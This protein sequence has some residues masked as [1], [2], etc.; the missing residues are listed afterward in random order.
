MEYASRNFLG[1]LFICSL[2]VRGLIFYGYL[3]RDHHYWQVDSGTYQKVAES[4]A[5]GKGIT[6]PDGTAHFYRVP[7]YSLFLA[8]CYRYLGVD[9]KNVLWIQLI[10]ASL[11]PLLIFFLA[12]L[13]FPQQRL[14]AYCASWWS[15]FHL[16]LVL[17]AGFFMTESLFILFL[18][19]FFL[20]FFSIVRFLSCA[21]S[22]PEETICYDPGLTI[23]SCYLPEPL[24]E[25]MGLIEYYYADS[26]I[27]KNGSGP[28]INPFEEEASIN[29]FIAGIF[30]GAATLFRPVGHYLLGLSLILIVCCKLDLWAKIRRSTMLFM[31]WVLIAGWWLIRNYLLLGTLFFHTLPGGHFLYLSAARVAMVINNCSYT[32]A[33]EIVHQEADLR[34]ELARQEK[35]SALN[36]IEAC[37]VNEALAREYF[38]AQPLVTARLWF[39]DIFRSLFS[40]YSAEIIYLEQGRASVNYFDKEHGF[41]QMFMRYFCPNINA[42]WLILLVYAEIFFFLMLWMGVL[43]TAYAA[44]HERYSQSS[45]P[46]A[47]GCLKMLPFM[48]L[49]M[50]ITLAGGYA[51]MRLPIAPLLIIW[52]SKYWIERLYQKIR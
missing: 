41:Y 22:L 36:P 13:F 43:G 48:M 49:F 29:A 9:T 46:T 16:G 30:L 10:L 39:T 11:I 33:R 6:N 17:Y 44:L 26:T 5:A 52:S 47:E 4:I 3:Q 8:F 1:M 32:Q 12:L 27:K 7:G 50:V 23:G 51:R 25:E 38:M 37:N 42:W 28:R 19:L 21:P 18:L 45:C 15:V 40:L 20:Y 31:G 35:G 24:E 14:V 34:M 2:L